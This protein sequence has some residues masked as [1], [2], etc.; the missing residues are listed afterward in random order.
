MLRVLAGIAALSA[1]GAAAADD[2]ALAELRAAV[3]VAET[4][5]ADRYAFTLDYRNL[6]DEEARVFRVRFDPRGA[7]GARW[8]AIDPPKDQ[9]GEKETAAFERM[10]KNDDADDA[11][12]YESLA[13]GLGGAKLIEADGAHATFAIPISDP[14][15]P[16][17]A[18]DALAAT[19]TLDRASGHVETVEVRSLRPFKPAAVAK[20]KSMRQVQRYEV[21]TPGGPAL[22]IAAESD[23]EGSAM[24][25]SFSSRT[26]LSYSEIEKVDAPPRAAGK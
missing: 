21:L 11:L 10:T 4:H 7:P 12:V 20:I 5:A 23:A 16:K 19:A 1:G 6:A 13:K 3:E 14:D 8:T 9:Y 18:K 15:L 22:L 24:F 26:R 2:A 17:A 25:K